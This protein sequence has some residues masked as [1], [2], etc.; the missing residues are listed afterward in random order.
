MCGSN[1]PSPL[2]PQ[3]SLPT[4]SLSLNPI[5][6]RATTRIMEMETNFA[7][8]IYGSYAIAA[9]LL[10]LMLAVSLYKLRSH[11][12]RL[13]KAKAGPHEP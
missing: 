7:T 6:L 1:L 3:I 11:K 2:S 9:I 5:P 13:D 8:Y 10:A 4:S 12:Q